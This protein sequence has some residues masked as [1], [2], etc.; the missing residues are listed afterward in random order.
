MNPPCKV[1]PVFLLEEVRAD[2]ESK[3]KQTRLWNSR[4]QMKGGR[5]NNTGPATQNIAYDGS[6]L[7]W[8]RGGSGPEVWRTTFEVTTNTLDWTSLGAGTRVPGGWQL[9]G[10]AL[11][12][13]CTV[14]ARGFA[15]EGYQSASSWFVEG[16]WGE[17]VKVSEPSSRTNNAGTT[18]SFSVVAGGTE[19]LR[20]QWFKDGVA[21]SDS[22]QVSGAQAAT[23]TLNSVF[24]ADEGAYSVE[25][26]H[27]SGRI[28]SAVA[29]LTVIEPIITSQPT[30]Q[31]VELN[32]SATL[33]I[34]GVGTPPVRYQWLKEGLPLANATNS[35]L[36][37]TNLQLID[38][39]NYSV[40]V[41]NPFG[42]VTSDVL[43]LTVNGTVAD[44]NFDPSPESGVYSLAV[45]PDGKII[46]GGEF[47]TLGGLPRRHIGRLNADGSLDAAFNPGG[48]G[49][50][51][52]LAVQVDG[53]I[54]VGGSFTTLGGQ[55][56]SSESAGRR[57]AATRQC[58]GAR[59]AGTIQ[60]IPAAP[61]TVS[62]RRPARVDHFSKSDPARLRMPL[63]LHRDTT[64][65]TAWIA[66]Q[67]ELGTRT[68]LS[69]PHL[70]RTKPEIMCES[71]KPKTAS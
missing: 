68:H 55:A 70:A 51:F 41:S 37:F 35:S 10:V 64:M 58:S 45:Q 48:D 14:R 52:S 40:V 1:S 44:S 30:N 8:R 2:A 62:F 50:V 56:R 49:P 53:K 31:A 61:A 27:A 3:R 26:S 65:T 71:T 38:A 54:L 42:S 57:F 25:I 12:T 13:S 18:A 6:T 11:P 32:G 5:L 20:Y 63:R 21:R 67:L 17:L 36:G 4:Q 43:F 23:L 66:Q 39:G 29:R 60:I 24:K 34:V 59:R 7:L 15:N 9:T 46:V 33:S 16:Y 22:G 28:T 19:P 69:H 47:S